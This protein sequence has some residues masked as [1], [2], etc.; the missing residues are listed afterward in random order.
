MTT[1]A[2]KNGIVAYDSRVTSDNVIITNREEKLTKI[3]NDTFII[4]AG[5][6]VDINNL[7][8]RFV[9]VDDPILIEDGFEPV[10]GVLIQS[11]DVYGIENGESHIVFNLLVSE[12]ELNDQK[13]HYTWG[14]GKDFATAAMDFGNS[15][16]EAVKYARTRDAMTGGGI[17]G[18][19]VEKMGVVPGHHTTG[20]K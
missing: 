18:F 16:K 7:K 2:Y 3:D 15:A 6:T 13:K 20:G 14:S 11:K 8:N 4:C 1:I 9:S 12:E 19:D 17:K 5:A 10:S